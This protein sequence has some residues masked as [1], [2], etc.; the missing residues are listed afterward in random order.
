MAMQLITG[1]S[2]ET[3]ILSILVKVVG[4]TEGKEDHSFLGTALVVHPLLEVEDLIGE[5][6]K[7]PSSQP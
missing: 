6:I 3:L 5:V 4:G 2:E 7:I 1:I